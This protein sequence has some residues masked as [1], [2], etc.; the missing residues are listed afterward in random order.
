M[1]EI[2]LEVDDSFGKEYMGKYVFKPLTW[3]KYA[4]IM[5]KHTV[6]NQGVVYTDDIKINAE[7][8][9]ATLA[10]QPETKPVT[11]ESLTSEDPDKG[12]PPM[13]GAKLLECACKVAGLNRTEFFRVGGKLA[14]QQP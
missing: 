5:Q 3:G 7:L 13:L 2:V 1:E 10:S 12:V 14:S 4:K 8:I 9:L 11:F 6:A